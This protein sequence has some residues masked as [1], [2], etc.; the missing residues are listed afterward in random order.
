V[1][2]CV[3]VCVCVQYIYI[4]IYIYTYIYMRNLLLDLGDF[5]NFFDGHFSDKLFPRLVGSCL[6][7]SRLLDQICRLGRL[8]FIRE[9][10]VCGLGF[11]V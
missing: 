1:C 7:A 5:V 3:C 9:G 2:V 8:H 11:W 6:D 4:Y 10:P